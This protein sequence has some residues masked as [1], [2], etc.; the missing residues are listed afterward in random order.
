MPSSPGDPSCLQRTLSPTGVPLGL[1][2]P[3][4][5]VVAVGFAQIIDPWREVAGRAR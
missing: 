5:N 2:A 1:G 4:H 3:T